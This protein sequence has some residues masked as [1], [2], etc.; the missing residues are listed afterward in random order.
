M[1]G[2]LISLEVEFTNKG[3]ELFDRQLYLR[4]AV[5]EKASSNTYTFQCTELQAIHYFFKFGRDAR[6]IK[7]QY[8][9]DKFISYYQEALNAYHQAD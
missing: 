5:Y 7:P 6:I 3:L 9:K 8:L 4:P 2:D 1:A